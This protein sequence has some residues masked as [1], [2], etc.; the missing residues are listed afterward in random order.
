[1]KWKFEFTG[2]NQILGSYCYIVPKKTWKIYWSEQSF[3]VLGPEGGRDDGDHEDWTRVHTFLSIHSTGQKEKAYQTKVIW[4]Y[5]TAHTYFSF[6][7]WL[8]ILCT[9]VEFQDIYANLHLSFVPTYI[10]F[11]FLKIMSENYIFSG[12]AYCEFMNIY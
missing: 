10:E 11:L 2:L 5:N 6:L 12:L 1:M 9:F 7:A 8:K 4:T 3:T